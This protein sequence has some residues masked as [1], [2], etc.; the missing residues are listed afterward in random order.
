MRNPSTRVAAASVGFF[1]PGSE[2]AG[3]AIVWGGGAVVAA[4]MLWL[5][6]AGALRTPRAAR[7]PRDVDQPALV[8]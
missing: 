7:E 5:A 8:A 3:V 6:V 4:M 2:V 1:L